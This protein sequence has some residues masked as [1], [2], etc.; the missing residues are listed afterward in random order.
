MPKNL[1]PRIKDGVESKTHFLYTDSKGRE[2]SV[3]DFEKMMSTVSMWSTN[4]VGYSWEGMYFGEDE[5]ALKN[6]QF[7]GF[8]SEEVI[9]QIEALT[10][11]S[12]MNH[13]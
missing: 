7:R 4:D 1:T 8:S 13:E 5:E 10:H 3:V 2:W 11:P 12:D 6:N 9:E